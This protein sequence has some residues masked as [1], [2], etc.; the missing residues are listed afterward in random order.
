M[1][2]H[3]ASYRAPG[4]A[5]PNGGGDGGWHRQR[6]WQQARRRRDRRTRPAS[7]RVRC[8]L[9]LPLHHEPA[10]GDPSRGRRPG[11]LG[12][13]AGR[14]PR[15]R[16]AGTLAAGGCSP[17]RRRRRATRRRQNHRHPNPTPLPIMMNRQTAES[18]R[19]PARPAVTRT[20]LM[21]V[22]AATVTAGDCRAGKAAVTVAPLTVT[23][24]TAAVGPGSPAP[25]LQSAANRPKKKLEK[26]SVEN[27]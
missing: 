16:W 27:Y 19:T 9:C 20:Q 5:P 13:C 26:N 4:A 25:R 21:P 14:R 23:R 3:R 17:A 6:R 7:T 22:P 12:G 24:T 15:F 10:G 1:A 2:S 8:S 11:R 18:E